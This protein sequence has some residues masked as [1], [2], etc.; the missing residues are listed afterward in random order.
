MVVR[1]KRGCHSG[2]PQAQ[3]LALFWI[4][5]WDV[6]APP[7]LG[8]SYS[9]FLHPSYDNPNL[10]NFN[11]TKLQQNLREIRQYKKINHYYK[12]CIKP[13]HILFLHYIYCIPTFLWKKLIKENHRDIKTSTQRKENRICQNRIV[14]SNL[15]CSK[16]SGTQ[17]IVKHQNDLRNLYINLPQK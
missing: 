15:I 8:S 14:R 2:H 5:A 11:H 3:L 7:S 10:E 12:Y 17:K 13:I 4:I 9:L 1:R 16:T 6:G